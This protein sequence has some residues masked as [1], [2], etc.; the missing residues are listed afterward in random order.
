MHAATSNNSCVISLSD[1]G[2]CGGFF[3]GWR[4]TTADNGSAL[5]N[6]W[7]L[8]T[9][10]LANNNC[11]AWLGLTG[12]CKTT[13]NNDALFAARQWISGESLWA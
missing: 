3:I 5:D 10:L 12:L 1:N 11:V 7:L 13:T 8:F 9:V 2:S 6:F 4:V